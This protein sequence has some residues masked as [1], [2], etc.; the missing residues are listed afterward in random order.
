MYAFPL[1]L[2]V[3][4]DFTGS[5][6]VRPIAYAFTAWGGALYLWAGILYFGQVLAAVRGARA[7]A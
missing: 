5:D 7:R 2:L 3:Q 1:L 4:D 6:V